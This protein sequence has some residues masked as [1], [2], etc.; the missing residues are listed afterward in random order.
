MPS[1]LAHC[2]KLLWSLDD[3]RVVMPSKASLKC[4]AVS[5]ARYIAVRGIAKRQQRC[6]RS[7]A[8][9]AHAHHASAVS[10]LPTSVDT[11]ATEFKENARQMRE[12]MAKMN[13]LHA[14]VERGG[15]EK[16]RQKHLARGKMLPREYV[17]GTTFHISWCRA[18]CS[19]AV[20]L[21]L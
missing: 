17:F 6:G 8:T 11:S 14:R 1:T 21:L 12:V 15:P 19:L 20:S 2:K 4:F 3:S 16:A 5:S 13:E 18:E 10:I 9:H 7:I